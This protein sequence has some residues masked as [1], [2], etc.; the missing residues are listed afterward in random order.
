MNLPVQTLL[1]VALSGSGL[2]FRIG[3]R[4]RSLGLVSYTRQSVR[5]FFRWLAGIRLVARLAAALKKT[6]LARRVSGWAARRAA[7]RPPDVLLNRND[8]DISTASDI[9]NETMF[10]LSRDSMY[11]IG[12][13]II[14]SSAYCWA[15]NRYVHAIDFHAAARVLF[16]VIPE[17]VW[18]T[19]IVPAVLPH[20]T[21]IVL[22]FVGLWGLSFVGG[23][24]SRGALRLTGWHRR[25]HLLEHSNPW[26]ELLT[27]VDLDDLP[28]ISAPPRNAPEG[29]PADA[30]A[31]AVIPLIAAVVQVGG[32]GVIYEGL[33]E[34]FAVGR[35]GHLSRL[36]LT[37]VKRCTFGESSKRYDVPSA[38]VVLRGSEICNVSAYFFVIGRPSAIAAAYED[39][40]PAATSAAPEAAAP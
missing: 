6:P 26:T 13:A 19:D 35:D 25:L 23:H 40:T 27:K 34:R 9:E 28:H 1:L 29:S 16:G 30:G 17:S 18:A 7:R 32:K 8:L 12:I 3:Y 2:L 20:K 37:D 22:F 11:A 4:S 5:R 24:V 21:R 33:L 10:S 31:L 36:V 15:V 39:D 38:R 14:L